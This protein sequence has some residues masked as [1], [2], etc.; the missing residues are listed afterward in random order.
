MLFLEVIIIARLCF[1][2]FITVYEL[3]DALGLLRPL[4]RR[5]LVAAR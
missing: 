5:I 4:D 3:A 1:G 2:T